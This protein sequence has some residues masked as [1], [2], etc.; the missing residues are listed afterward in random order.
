MIAEDNPDIVVSKLL[1][2]VLCIE[3]KKGNSGFNQ[4][5]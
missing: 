1:G 5:V 2:K 4:R 3:F